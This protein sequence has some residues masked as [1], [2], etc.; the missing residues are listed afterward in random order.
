MVDCGLGSS[1]DD[2]LDESLA[3]DATTNRG[4]TN[5]LP[6]ALVAKAGL[7]APLSE[8]Q[9]F[10]RRYSRRL[11]KSH[12][13][14]NGL[15]RTNWLTAVGDRHAYGDLVQFFDNEVREAGTQATVRTYLSHLVPGISG[16]AFHGVIRLAYAL[17]VD[18]PGR[19][20]AAL[21]YLAS[22]ASE[23]A[24]LDDVGAKTDDPE[25]L[26]NEMTAGGAWAS[27]PSLTL[28]SEEMNWVGAQPGFSSLA[29]SLQVDE[30]T[31]RRLAR[32][33]LKVY[34]TTNDFTALHGVTGMEALARVRQFVDDTQ[35]FDRYSFQALAAAFATIGAPAVW[36]AD[37]LAEA[38]STRT[39]SPEAVAQRAAWSDD[40]HVAKIVFTSQR[41]Y[42]VE[43]DSLYW[44]VSERA[45][46]SDSSL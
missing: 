28:I 39:L 17:D 8:L 27:V 40:E 9:R 11:V 6:M 14:S 13:G 3:F 2:L 10:S 41:L 18:S 25:E 35:R 34:A 16:A 45:V 44:F 26:L 36:S 1:L 22:S 30:E 20:A 7:G 42:E 4:L 31:P 24:P 32:A 29:S 12:V 15:A 38:S 37:R 21:A 46:M 5:H 23:L 19:V 33:A 43:R